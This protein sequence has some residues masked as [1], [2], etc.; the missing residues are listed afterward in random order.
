M[1]GRV[2]R[3]TRTNVTLALAMAGIVYLFWVLACH[4]GKYCANV[5][6]AHTPATLTGR[7]LSLA[8]GRWPAVFDWLGPVWLVLSLYLV[9]RA[10]RQQRVISWSW[11]VITSQALAALL[12]ATV[13]A[14]AA[15]RQMDLLKPSGDTSADW[16]VGLVGISVVAW[17][18][19]LAL[20]IRDRTACSATAPAWPTGSKPRRIG[21]R[22]GRHFRLPISDCRIAHRLGDGLL[23]GFSD[24]RMNV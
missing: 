4:V 19:A 20:L 2:R 5:L 18:A 12:I 1:L 6:A 3:T 8:F 15:S 7:A 21:G 9:I 23:N 11:L 14:M 17:L 13:S 16:S 22:P 24:A 10:S